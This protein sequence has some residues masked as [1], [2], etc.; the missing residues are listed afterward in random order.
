M[1]RV[2]IVG[3]GFMGWIHYLAYL[4]IAGVQL[5]AVCTRDPKK[6]AGDWT[7]IQGNFGP[8]GEVVDLTGVSC[9]ADVDALLA[10]PEIDLVDVCLPPH[11]HQ[12][13][14]IRALQAGKHVLCE[15]P[16]ALTAEDCD[17][18]LAAAERAGKQILVA[19]VLPFFPEYAYLRQI[20]AEGR[21]GKLLGGNFKRVI[22]DP[23][24]LPDFYDLTRVGGPL[25]DLHVHDAHLI[26][27]LFGMPTSLYCRGRFRGDVVSY[28]ETL[29]QFADP[30]LVVRA[31]SG[32]IDQ[33]GR[34]FTHGFE[35]H[36]ERATLQFEFAGFTDQG[37]LMP[38][39][40]LVSNESEGGQAAQQVVRPELGDGDPIRG[41][42]YEL[43][44]VIDSISQGKSSPILSGSLA[45]DAIVI[46][47]QQTASAKSGQMVR[48]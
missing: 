19:H 42:E 21:Y 14:A 24:W 30:Q 13:V 38:L 36:L 44:E 18:M 9:Y 23:L 47:H 17:A 8:R 10:D 43:A 37:E 25:V 40:M 6:R 45:R 11:L 35:V 12:E 31:T 4:R 46:C 41:F 22:S 2:G 34:P 26:R 29:F 7:S 28:C 3:I 16:M 33:Q 1:L 5:K 39:K 32:V 20:V 48:L 27:M 15:K